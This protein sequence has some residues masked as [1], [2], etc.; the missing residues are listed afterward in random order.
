MHWV[1]ANKGKSFQVRSCLKGAALG[2]TTVRLLAASN[3]LYFVIGLIVFAGL[4]VA[5]SRA[6]ENRLD[7]D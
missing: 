4:A 1:L 5:R 3:P 7:D 6:E 2:V